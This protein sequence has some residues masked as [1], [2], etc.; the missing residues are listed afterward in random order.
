[1]LRQIGLI[2]LAT[3]IAWHGYGAILGSIIYYT[4]SRRRIWKSTDYSRWQDAIL[5][6][7]ISVVLFALVW[8]I[9]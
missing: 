3:S 6:T 9:R 4:G 2:V 8:R 1:M 5:I 7:C